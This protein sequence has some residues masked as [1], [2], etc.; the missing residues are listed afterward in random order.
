MNT[1]QSY[2]ILLISIVLILIGKFL[3]NRIIKWISLSTLF[4]FAIINIH[5]MTTRKLLLNDLF[6]YNNYAILAN[7]TLSILSILITYILYLQMND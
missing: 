5:I 2:N 4:I 6:N 1:F 3:K 7:Y